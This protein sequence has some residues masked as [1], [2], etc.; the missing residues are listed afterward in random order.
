MVVHHLTER[1]LA[2]A[3]F[4]NNR[5]RSK[6]QEAIDNEL[7]SVVIY[8]DSLLNFCPARSITTKVLTCCGIRHSSIGLQNGNVETIVPQTAAFIVGQE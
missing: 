4:Y 6:T 7:S 8:I 5:D 3:V 1:N 2:G